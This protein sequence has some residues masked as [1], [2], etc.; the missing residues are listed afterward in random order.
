MLT[1]FQKR[2][3][4]R[5]FNCL[6][7]DGNGYFE[8]ADVDIIVDRLATARG[9]KPNTIEYDQIQAGIDTIWD[10]ARQYGYS[11]NPNQVT[12]A[13]W[14]H[15][16]ELVL[17]TEEWRENYMKAVTRGVFDLVDA[18]GNGEI[19]LDE[20]TQLMSAFGVEKGIPEWAFRFLDLN[21]DGHISKEEFVIIVEQ[22]HISEDRNAPGNY[23]FGPY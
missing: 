15:H 3:L 16:E 20:Y 6:D 22:F 1:P 11:Q 2:K 23:L 8:K 13:D 4:T 12:L 19:S 5:Y 9:Y 18:D 17:S 7:A 21:G 14:L 10:N